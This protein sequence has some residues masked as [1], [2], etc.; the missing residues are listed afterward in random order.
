MKAELHHPRRILAAWAVALALALGAAS[1]APAQ[2]PVAES[3]AAAPAEPLDPFG[4][5][6]PA[7][8]VSGFV[9]AIADEDYERASRFLDLSDIAASRRA[10]LGPAMAEQLQERLD[11]AGSFLP[12]PQLSE[13]PEGE[14]VDGLQPRLEKVGTLE[15]GGTES[16]VLLERKE[17]ADGE[18]HWVI[19]NETLD[20]ALSARPVA[21]STLAEQWLPEMVT[22]IDIGGAP[23]SHWITLLAVT[24]AAF[25]TCWLLLHVAFLL[26][27]RIAGGARRMHRFVRAVSPPLALLAAVLAGSLSA[28]AL[29]VSIVARQAM[30]WWFELAGWVALGW[31]GWRVIDALSDRVLARLNRK[32]R[33]NATSIIRFAGRLAKLVVIAVTLMALL[34]AMGFDVTAA[35]AALGIGGI[36]LALGAQKTVEN[37]IASISILSDRPFRIGDVCRF[38]SIVGTVEDIGMRSSRIRTLDRTLL[39]IPN[40]NL[41]NSEIENYSRRDQGFFHP[42]LHLSTEVGAETLDILLPALRKALAD[43]RLQGGGARVRLLAPT[44]DRLPIEVFGY[45]LTS[46]YDEYL[47]I[48][49]EL[50][51]KLL[52]VLARHDVRLVPPAL[53]I[54]SPAAEPSRRAEAA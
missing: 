21:D 18:A 22:D 28:P 7:G 46:D 54:S 40:G 34:D 15:I 30:G 32:G 42:M 19:A 27:R 8:T 20:L 36:A 47:E 11:Q 9:D 3:E 23:A 1:P 45:I 2:V 50:M 24:I 48:Q 16:P 49:E 14:S 53:H 35:V 31:L 52:R 12:R 10:K 29:S 33:L 17:G 5:T 13:L 4:R 44:P 25:L 6:T 51:L 38:G 37:L 43:P 41:S 39:T 26:L